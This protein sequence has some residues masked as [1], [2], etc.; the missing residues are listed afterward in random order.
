MKKVV[1]TVCALTFGCSMAAYATC[2]DV[3]RFTNPTSGGVCSDHTIGPSCTD[4]GPGTDQTCVTGSQWSDGCGPAS[5]FAIQYSWAPAQGGYR[6]QC[7]QTHCVSTAV[8]SYIRLA[9]GSTFCG[10]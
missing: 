6:V 8:N 10:G 9:G 1:A 5:G 4:D 2:Y 3:S 7:S